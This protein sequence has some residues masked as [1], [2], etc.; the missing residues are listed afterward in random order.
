MGRVDAVDDSRDGAGTAWGNLGRS[1]P[2]FHRGAPRG[3]NREQ[4]SS[5][6]PRH[7]ADDYRHLEDFQHFPRA[8]DEEKI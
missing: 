6:A 1:C 2:S 3:W 7:W 4:F 8:Y 5:R